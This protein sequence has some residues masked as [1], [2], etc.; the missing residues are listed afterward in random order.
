MTSDIEDYRKLVNFVIILHGHIVI[1]KFKQNKVAQY[2]RMLNNF[3]VRE[4]S[5]AH[6]AATLYH[7]LLELQ[8]K[9]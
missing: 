3:A 7:N 5:N 1:D 9:E 8:N 6:L 4:I 2:C